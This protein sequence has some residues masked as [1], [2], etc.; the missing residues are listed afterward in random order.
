[1][2]SGFLHFIFAFALGG[3]I[4]RI[5]HANWVCRLGTIFP[6]TMKALWSW[7]EL[8][9]ASPFEHSETL[10]YFVVVVACWLCLAEF[11]VKHLKLPSG[12]FLL[13][14]AFFGVEFVSIMYLVL[15]VGILE[16][17]RLKSSLRRIQSKVS[18][19]CLSALL[20]LILKWFFF[21]LKCLLHCAFVWGSNGRNPLKNID[22]TQLKRKDLRNQ[23][24]TPT[25]E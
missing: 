21:V 3:E 10:H 15:G 25:N 4:L 5:M 24:R 6:T 13:M 20:L 12:N 2:Y 16:C 11:Q 1:M 9:Y 18:S 22:K 17:G 7:R 23:Q 14:T 8:T 19:S